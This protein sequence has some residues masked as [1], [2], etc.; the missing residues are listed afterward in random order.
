MADVLNVKVNNQWVGVPAL[1]GFKSAEVS[2][3][4]AEWT[5]DVVYKS[6]DGLTMNSTVLVSPHPDSMENILSSKVY[7]NG[8]TTSSD[9]SVGLNFKKTGTISTSNAMVFEVLFT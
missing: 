6:I 7:C 5:S 3:Y 2:I 1:T 9:G 8:V 4:Q